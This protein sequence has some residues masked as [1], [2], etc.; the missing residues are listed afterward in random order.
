[1]TPLR[2]QV[3]LLSASIFPLV[4]ELRSIKSNKVYFVIVIQLTLKPNLNDNG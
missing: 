1:M 3:A 2:N 4:Y